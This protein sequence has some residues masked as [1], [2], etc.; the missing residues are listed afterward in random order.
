MGLLYLSIGLLVG[1]LSVWFALKSRMDAASAQTQSA[2]DNAVAQIRAQYE[3]QLATLNERLSG[4]DAQISEV[5]ARAQ[6]LQKRLEALQAETK[7]LL[8]R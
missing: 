4:K 3:P 7:E 6:D 2:V 8:K 1:A 5:Q